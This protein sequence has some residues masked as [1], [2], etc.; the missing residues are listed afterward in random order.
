MRKTQ[1]TQIT[2]TIGN[3]KK[4][5]T[6]LLT[7]SAASF[8]L[9]VS[10]PSVIAQEVNAALQARDS[11]D[12]VEVIEVSGVRSSL[13]NALNTKREAASIVDAISATDID[14]LPALDLGEALQALPGVQLNSETEG[15]QSTISLRGLS[16]GFVKT[17]AFGQSFATPSPAGGDS[18]GAPNPF[19]AFESGI[20]DGVTVVKSPTADLQEGGV[21]GVIDKK[22]QQAL[23]KKDGLATISIG[24]QYEDLPESFSPN[25]KFS[26]VKHLIKDK[27]AVAFKFSQSGQEFRRDTFDIIDYV[28]VE[29]TTNSRNTN[30]GVR[31]TNVAE[32]RET[33]GVPADAEIRIP[34]KA[35]NVTQYS[36]GDRHSFSGNI[37]YRATDDLKLG[38]HILVSERNLNDGTKEVTNFETG[39]HLTNPGNDYYQSQVTLDMDVAPF[40][41]TALSEDGIG[42]AYIAPGVSFQN[43]KLQNENRKTT[44]HEKSEGVILYADYIADDWV[45]DAKVSHSK[46][47]NEFTNIG[48]GYNHVGNRATNQTPTGFNGYINTGRGDVNAIQV[49]GGLEVP[50]VYDGLAWPENVPITVNSVTL[51]SPENQGRNLNTYLNGR[52][53]DLLTD[54]SSAEFNAQRYTDFGLGNGLRFNSIKFGGRFQTEDMESIDRVN[55]LGGINLTNLNSSLISNNPLSAQQSAF[56]NGQIPGTFDENSGW[57]TV[58]NEGT[59]AALQN[60]IVTDRNNLALPNNLAQLHESVMMNRAGFWDR[61]RTPGGEAW[62]LDY[63]FDSKQ[64]ITAI[65]LMTDF[66]GELPLD[67]TYTGN[68][69]VRYVETDNTFDGVQLGSDE[70]GNFTGT[71]LTFNDS[72]SNTLPM[73][74]I[75]FELTE[76]VILRAAY[77]EGIVR[78]NINGQRPAPSLRPGNNTINLDLPN[79][80]L[81]P[82]SANNYDLSLEWYNREGSAISIGYFK[83]DITNLFGTDDDIYCPA[84]GSNALVNELIGAIELVGQTCQE[85][86]LFTPEL[87]GVEGEVQ[88][89]PRNREVII[90]NPVNSDE[91]LAVEGFELAIQ[92]KLDFLPYPWNGLGGVFNFTKVKQSGAEQQLSRVSPKSFN[93]ITYY[94]NDGLSLRFAYNWRDDQT[95]AGANSFLGTGTRVLKA[96]GR[97]DFSGSYA[98]TKDLKVYLQGINLTDEIGVSHYGY[99]DDAIHQLSYSG[100]IYKV[101]ASY[102]F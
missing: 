65:Y 98:L 99:N 43:G 15:R 24:A 81:K 89:E 12:S 18:V 95:T 67:I 102:K 50:Y 62:F 5:K 66:S 83:K 93:I 6:H 16:S 8:I 56:F 72:Y 41:Y 13:E 36:D 11:V 82:Y 94:E 76:D 47:T 70:A 29:D 1:I 46:G 64:D 85:V 38:A 14:A 27:L 87:T 79:A 25:I 39:L 88:P 28:S 35:K 17:T 20:F 57:A 52:T 4:L 58:D 86:A 60:G 32:Y 51:R 30:G 68:F 31:A 61:A 48:V 19:S 40:A 100:R 78:P 21:A 80:T 26:G 74:N 2:P 101:S 90:Q 3:N 97:L 7:G 59:I 77:S 91:T 96:K 69:G 75:A 22:L 63:N 71:P 44:F 37:E 10:S 49:S 73:A 55:A 34:H 42:Q 9:A 23:S 33:W 45:Y 84:D 53:R 92:Q 54:M